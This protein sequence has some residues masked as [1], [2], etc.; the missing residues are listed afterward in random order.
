MQPEARS[1]HYARDSIRR[2]PRSVR[3]HNSSRVI[4]SIVR[5]VETRTCLLPL[6][7]RTEILGDVVDELLTLQLHLKRLGRVRHNERIRRRG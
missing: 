6:C 5:D 4:F 1:R 3:G 2:H 7:V